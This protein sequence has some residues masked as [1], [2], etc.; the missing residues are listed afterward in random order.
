MAIKPITAHFT[1]SGIPHTGLTPSIDIIRL[2]VTVN[3]PVITGGS[4]SEIGSGWYRYDFTTYDPTQSYVFTIDGGSSLQPAERYK[5]GGN[6]SY[7]ED[8][9]S[10]VLDEPLINH[11]A[12]GS[13]SDVVTKIKTDTA[14]LAIN[15]VTLATLL[16]TMLKYQ[17]NRT[18]LNAAAATLTIYDDD[19]TTP[20][21]IFDLKDLRGM[22]SV[23]E[24]CDRVPRV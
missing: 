3:T 22:P 14:T 7:A 10:V 2:D 15:D 17:R 8:I 23:Q 19:A 1:T 20:I 6:E 18:S 13:L 21:T 5:C 11:T 4:L 24:V 12:T 9:T 16:N